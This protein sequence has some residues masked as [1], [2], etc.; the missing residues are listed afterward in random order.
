MRKIRGHSA[1]LSTLGEREKEESASAVPDTISFTTS[2]PP[3][4]RWGRRPTSRRRSG[5]AEASRAGSAGPQALLT[6]ACPARRSVSATSS[7]RSRRTDPVVVGTRR[8][9]L[10]RE[11][12]VRDR[13]G[14]EVRTN[15]S[16]VRENKTLQQRPV[17]LATVRHEVAVGK[18]ASC[19]RLV[20]SRAELERMQSAVRSVHCAKDVPKSGRARPRARGRSQ[21][22]QLR[23]SQNPPSGAPSRPPLD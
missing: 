7:N 5:G 3:V 21:V 11:R 12:L 15:H 8:G 6:S 2:Q 10:H 13:K 16:F 4:S 14:G 22:A 18:V 19:E 1:A 17:P 23:P 9:S 20:D